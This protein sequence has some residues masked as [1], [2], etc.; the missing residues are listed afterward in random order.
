MLSL[1]LSHTPFHRTNTS[2][3]HCQI[4]MAS[5]PRLQRHLSPPPSNQ[6]AQRGYHG[7]SSLPPSQTSNQ[8][9]GVPSMPRSSSSS[10]PSSPS[11]Q[12]QTQ[13]IENLRLR[14]KIA[15]L[16][17]AINCLKSTGGSH[18]LKRRYEYLINKGTKLLTLISYLQQDHF[19][20]SVSAWAWN[21]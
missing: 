1:C 7:Y 14:R 12:W 20:V 9:D 10:R 3:P 15:A 11:P 19:R 18:D 21:P 17:D 6:R 16:E 13:D 4:P 2:Q 8:Q 5:T